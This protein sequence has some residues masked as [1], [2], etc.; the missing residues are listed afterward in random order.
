MSESTRAA[1]LAIGT[2]ITDGDVVDQNSAW[3]SVRLVDMGFAVSEH[4]SVPDSRAAILAAVRELAKSNQLLFVTGGLGPTSDDFTREI[5]AE[6]A[7]L[8]L[9]LSEDS[10]SRIQLLLESRGVE[11]TETQKRQ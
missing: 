7:G 11:A 5:I 10:W 1:T 3:L 8:P 4:R 9:E 2:E 6:A